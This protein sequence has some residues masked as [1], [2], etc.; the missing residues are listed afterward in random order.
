MKDNQEFVTVHLPRATGNEE[1]SLFVA[2]NGKGYTI[3]RGE[4]VKVP[5]PVADILDEAERQR[6]RQMEYI[7]T[8]QESTGQSARNAG[9]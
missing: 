8:Q 5:R 1:D 4:A 6:R 3:R 7:R 2:L 9:L